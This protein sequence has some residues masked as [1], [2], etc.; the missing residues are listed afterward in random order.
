MYDIRMQYILY[1]ILAVY[2]TYGLLFQYSKIGFSLLQTV[3]LIFK[4]EIHLVISTAII[5]LYAYSLGGGK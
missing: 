3:T 2:L 5:V 4:L 1:I